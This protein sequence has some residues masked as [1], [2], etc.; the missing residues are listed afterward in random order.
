MKIKTSDLEGAAL[1]WAVGEI[2]FNR[3]IAQGSHVKS[4]VLDD[5]AKGLCTDPYSTDW[6]Q[7]G[8]I[9]ERELIEIHLMDDSEPLIWSA[10]LGDPFGAKKVQGGVVVVIDWP[11]PIDSGY[12]VLRRLPTGR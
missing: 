11:N 7:G 8:P 9:I 5:H 3:L 1:D 4:W 2:E 10:C 12:A 6:A